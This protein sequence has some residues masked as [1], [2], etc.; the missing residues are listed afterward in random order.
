MEA[1]DRT[2]GTIAVVAG[3]IAAMKLARCGQFFCVDLRKTSGAGWAIQ[4]TPEHQMSTDQQQEQQKP[5]IK[6]FAFEGCP[7]TYSS[8][9]QHD[10]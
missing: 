4:A 10:L 5:A 2:P 1:N 7:A 6:W 9:S 3:L 8:R